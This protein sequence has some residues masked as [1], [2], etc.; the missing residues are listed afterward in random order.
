MTEVGKIRRVQVNPYGNNEILVDV[1]ISPQIE[2]EEIRYRS[3]SRYVWAVPELG[4]IVEVTQTTGGG[5]VAHSARHKQ[6]QPL[7]ANLS[8]GDIAVK[9]ADGVR[10]RFSKQN[11]GTYNVDLDCDGDLQFVA[12]NIYVGS[13][14][15]RK[16]VATEDHTH[17][18]NYNGGGDNSSTL[19]GTTDGPDDVTDTTIE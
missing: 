15:N 13:D 14:G 19:S 11:D 16:K 10:F 4:D 12:N 6:E 17:T 18:F 3:G 5:H 8:N 7:P 1:R 9:I 2:Y